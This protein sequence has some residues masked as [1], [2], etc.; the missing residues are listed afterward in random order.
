MPQLG[1]TL[2]NLVA[3]SLRDVR[4]AVAP[5]LDTRRFW[6]GRTYG[7]LVA[8]AARLDFVDGVN[9]HR[10][11]LDDRDSLR[12]SVARIFEPGETRYFASAIQPGDV[13]IDVGGNI[14]YFTLL[15]ASKVGAAGRVEAFEPDPS[16]FA[17]LSRNIAE[18]GYSS[19]VLHNRAVW[20]K[21]GSL[22]LYLSE[23]NRGDHRAYPSEEARRAVDIEAVRLDD[24]FPDSPGRSRVDFVKM[25]IQGAEYHALLGMRRLLERNAGVRV[26][27]ELWPNG[28]RRAGSSA[29]D[30]LELLSG[31]GFR[32]FELDEHSGTP[33][34]I[35]REALLARAHADPEGF[36]NLLCQRG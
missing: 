21:P 14:G 28:L 4:R 11:Y 36:S 10:M 12:L 20:S 16:N 6:L 26:V 3:R 24:L 35:E 9:G 33:T 8:S 30:L 29:E 7:R 15:F 2:T 25:D 19:V 32:F 13:V 27:T 1:R 31:L 23:T 18:N 5:N 34:E 22:R 17:L